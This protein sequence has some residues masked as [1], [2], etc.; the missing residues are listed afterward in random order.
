MQPT[1][2]QPKLDV[3]AAQR[4]LSGIIRQAQKDNEQK[5]KGMWFM[6]SLQWQK[7]CNLKRQLVAT[8]AILDLMIECI[9]M[10][11]G[12]MNSDVRGQRQ[13]IEN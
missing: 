2:F 7:A 4:F 10:K 6:C 5:T 11:L 8:C 12:Q 1:S 13:N 3:D 9:I